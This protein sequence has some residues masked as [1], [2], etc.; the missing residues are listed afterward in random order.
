MAVD[1]ASCGMDEV[2]VE[3]E[4]AADKTLLHHACQCQVAPIDFCLFEEGA[5]NLFAFFGVEE[6]HDFAITFLAQVIGAELLPNI[7]A[8]S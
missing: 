7:F 4:H 1:A 8:Q 6:G 3:C 2:K 5:N